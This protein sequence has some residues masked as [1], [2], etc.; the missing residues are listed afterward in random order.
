VPVPGEVELVAVATLQHLK[1]SAPA[2]GVAVEFTL[3]AGVRVIGT[4][5]DRGP[6]FCSLTPTGLTC[7]LDYLSTDALTGKAVVR[8]AVE[9]PGELTIAVQVRHDSADLNQADDVQTLVINRAQ[10]TPLALARPADQRCVVPAILGKRLT[11]AG[12]AIRKAGCALGRV[13]RRAASR[14]AAGRV[15][16]QSRRPRTELPVGSR[17]DVVVGRGRAR[18]AASRR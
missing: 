6:G 15:I 2:L 1:S 16:G 5:T 8:L 14:N 12:A 18:E 11:S 4:S 9:R 3:P 10:T 13:R 17:I 7:P